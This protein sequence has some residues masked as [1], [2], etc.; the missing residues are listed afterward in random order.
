[1]YLFLRYHPKAHL[2]TAGASLDPQ[3][4]ALCLLTLLL[5]V[6]QG[7]LSNYPAFMSP[8]LGLP[9]ESDNC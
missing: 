5:L 9:V 8:H 7:S 1:M 6:L 3:Q 4:P 2:T